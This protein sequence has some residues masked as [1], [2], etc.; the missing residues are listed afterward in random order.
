MKT[1]Q[2]DLNAK[3]QAEEKITERSDMKQSKED[4]LSKY[5]DL[6]NENEKLKKDLKESIFD[7]SEMIISPAEYLRRLRLVNMNKRIEKF[8]ENKTD[9]PKNA[10]IYF[11]SMMKRW[12]GGKL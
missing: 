8:K 3:T 7:I 11:M 2:Q 5:K 10:V 6:L 12:E 4:L 1:I 9:Y